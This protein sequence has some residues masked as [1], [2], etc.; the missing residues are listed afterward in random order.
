[1]SRLPPA[2]AAAAGVGPG[3][4]EEAFALLDEICDGYVR[5][6]AQRCA[7]VR[8][9]IHE[10]EIRRLLGEYARHCA[11]LL[12]KGGRPEW[13][14]RALAG[15]SIDDQRVDYRDWL[16][17]LGDVYLAARTAGLD[18]SPALKRIGALSNAE[19]HRATPTPTNEALA[20]FEESAYFATSILP[21]MH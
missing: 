2:A 3:P 16:M 15:V 1:M 19:G 9:V 4:K 14:E 5:A 7:L 10:H 17:A 8:G 12:E 13:L 20:R 18:P 11:R 6:D 21:R